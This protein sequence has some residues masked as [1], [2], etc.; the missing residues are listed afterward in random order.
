MKLV[1]VCTDIL[2]EVWRVL[3]S[4]AKLSGISLRDYLTFLILRSSPI[5]VEDDGASDLLR[6]IIHINKEASQGSRQHRALLLATRQESVDLGTDGNA[7]PEGLRPG[8]EV[9]E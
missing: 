8:S 5:S 6:S 2:P 3:G 7:E 1:H 4:N 9:S